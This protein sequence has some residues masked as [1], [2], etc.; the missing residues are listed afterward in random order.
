MNIVLLSGGSGRRLWPLSNDVRSKQFLKIYKSEDGSY[1]SMIQ[2][3]Y[4]QIK[5]VIPDAE[6]TIAT[7]EKQL[8][9]IRNQIS[10]NADISVEPDRKDTFPAITLACSYLADKKRI[11]MDE[12]IIVCPVDPYVDNSYFEQF[13]HLCQ[14]V[15]TESASIAL[16]GIAPTYPS[17]KYG[18]ILPATKDTV[19]HVKS[20]KEKPDTATAVQYI[21]EGALWNA[22]VFAFKLSYLLEEAHK[23]I[24]FTDYDDL[25]QTY[26]SLPKIS[27][28]Y[29]ILEKKKNIQVLSYIGEWKDVG[30]WNTFA[31]AMSEPAIGDVIESDTCNNVNIIN[32]LDIPI[33]AM[34]LK[35]MI[36]SASPD[37]IIVSDKEQSS[38]IKPYVDELKQKIRFAEKSWGSYKV[39]CVEKE[40]TTIEVTLNMGHRM[41]YH[42]HE[43]R[44][45]IWNVIMGHGLVRINDETSP[46][47]A[48]D[49]IKLPRG[50][51]H[52]I[53]AYSDLRIIEVQLGEDI[54]EEDKQVFEPL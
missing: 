31:E 28:D 33:L 42:S 47:K 53:F 43:R 19:S 51:K 46:V 11:P 12:V 54:C 3:V 14:M 48:G 6:I 17:E 32:E 13:A 15:N 44:D 50:C 16:L 36:I 4:R 39:I 27:F 49:I 35:N 45:E 52:T 21:A 8:S 20:F 22:G 10:D 30:T 5:T 41:R 7:S 24:D 40:S 26:S 1:E 25:Y 2:R 34:G 37:G 18:Y 9:T 38:Y 23:L 29:A